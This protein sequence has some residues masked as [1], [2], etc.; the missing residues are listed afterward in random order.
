MLKGDVTGLAVLN[1]G[2]KPVLPERDSYQVTLQGGIVTSSFGG[3]MSKQAVQFQ[4]SVYQVKCNYIGLDGGKAQWLANFFNRNRGLPFVATLMLDDGT[5]DQY[6]VQRVDNNPVSLTGFNG[7]ISVTYEVEPAID[8]CFADWTYE[9][10]QCVSA[11]DWCKIFNY[12]KQGNESLPEPVEP[13]FLNNYLIPL[14]SSLAIYE[15]VE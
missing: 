5:L 4:S 14:G 2:G 12:T 15:E 3:G 6:V 9:A 1:Y 13:V 10:Y 7:S 8:T 11:S